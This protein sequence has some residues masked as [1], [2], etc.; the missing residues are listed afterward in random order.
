VVLQPEHDAALLGARQE[1]LEGANDPAE[2]LLIGV[3]L[4]GRLDP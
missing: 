4:R 1:L 3:A 2:R